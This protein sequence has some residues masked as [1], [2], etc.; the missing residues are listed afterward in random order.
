MTSTGI[1]ACTYTETPLNVGIVGPVALTPGTGQIT[2]YTAP[3]SS[4]PTT[5]CPDEGTGTA[6]TGTFGT[7]TEALG[8]AQTAYN[9]LQGLPSGI[10]LSSTELGNRTLAP[11]VYKSTT[12]YDLTAGPLTLDAQGNPDAYWIFQMG[13]SLQV[14]TPTA[15][16]SVILINGANASNVFWAVGSSAVINYGG[17]GTMVGTVISSAGLTVSSPGLATSSTLT[18]IDG[19]VIALG[20]SVTMVNT[21][22]NVPAQ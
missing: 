19:R 6:S 22:I 2:I 18:Y 5:A 12:S 15:P 20:A 13:S 14:G 17:G 21:I 10:T 11:G 9:T 4:E 1:A 8:E 3:G 7:A 16:E